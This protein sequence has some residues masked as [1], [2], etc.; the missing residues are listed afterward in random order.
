[1]V[2]FC[3]FWGGNEKIAEIRAGSLSRLAASLY[4]EPAHRLGECSGIV[5]KY[6]SHHW[7]LSLCHDFVARFQNNEVVLFPCIVDLCFKLT[8]KKQT[9]LGTPLINF[10]FCVG[11][12]FLKITQQKEISGSTALAIK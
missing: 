10:G 3:G 8:H 2:F 4:H 9:E 6:L 12:G 7:V 1:M 5:V 11:F